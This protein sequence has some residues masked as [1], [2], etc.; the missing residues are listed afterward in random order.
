MQLSIPSSKIWQRIVY[1]FKANYRIILIWLG[2]LIF[3][4]VAFYF[5]LQKSVIATFVVLFGLLAQAF[6]GLLSLIS[7]IPFI[8]PMI[9][10]VISLPLFLLINGITYI[11]TIVF[12]RKKGGKKNIIIS[13]SLTNALL[14]GVI[15]GFILGKLF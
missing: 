4:K 10:K 3:I 7:Y 1:F 8:G 15:I 2:I 5:H 14:I 13:R 9:T 12:I 6:T 11:T